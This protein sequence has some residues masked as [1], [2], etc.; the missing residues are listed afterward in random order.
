MVLS[1]ENKQEKKNLT[2]MRGVWDRRV[3]NA[4]LDDVRFWRH[5]KDDD[6]DERGVRA[7]CRATE[8]DGCC[9]RVICQAAR[10]RIQNSR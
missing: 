7:I 1:G 2:D 5:G 4:C 9:L 6:I 8:M 10:C 3:N